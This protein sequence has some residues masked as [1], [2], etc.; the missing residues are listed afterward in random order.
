MR[1]V[2]RVLVG[3]FMF[4]LLLL[5]PT[6]AQAATTPP[7]KIPLTL[8]L[9]QE[10][11]NSPIQSEGFSTIDLRQLIIDLTNEN[12]EFRDQFYQRLQTQINRSKTPLGLDLSESLIQGE[13]IASKLGLQTPLSQAAL[14]SLLSPIEQE[15]LQTDDRFFTKPGEQIPLVTVFRGPL[16]FP[17]ARFTGI[18]SFADTLFLQRLEASQTTFIQEV[19]CSNTRFDRLAD[20]S[21]AT[22]GRGI[23]FSSSAFFDNANFNQVQFLGVANFTGSTFDSTANFLQTEFAQLANFSRTRWLQTADFREVNWHD[24]ALLNKSHFAK[25]LL[26][27]N[28]TLEK[29]TTFRESHFQEPVVLQ[30]VSL[31]DQVDFSSARFTQGAYLNVA[32]MTFD[33]NLAKILGDTGRIGRVFSVSRLQDNEDVLR[34]LVRNFRNQQQIPDANQLEYTTQQLRRQQLQRYLLGKSRINPFSPSWLLDALHWLGLSLLLLLSEDGTSFGLVFGVG[35]VAIAFFSLLFWLIDRWRRRYPQPILPTYGETAYMLGTFTVV[36]VTGIV[37]IFRTGE[38]PWL[39]LLC[40]GNILLPV[41]LMLVWRLYQKGRYHNL[42][43]VSY[44]VEDGSLRQLH[45]LVGRL[46]IMPRFSIFR[47]RYLP[48]LWE[49]RWSWLNYYDFSLNNLLKFGFN[50]IRLRDEHLP[51]II[52]TLAWYQWSLGILYIALLL[53]T[54]SRTIPGL[55]LF[56]YL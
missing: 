23:S 51:G 53:W 19:D 40:L 47:D 35:M 49:R 26:L 28:A 36:T 55:N 44:F 4:L 27:T 20:F 38:Q 24:R 25:S 50:D 21:H 1:N 39:T 6:T 22:F 31:L 12:G 45:L 52:T 34:N 7:E 43:D 32:G 17:Q 9:L 56:I 11:L 41:P 18:V 16:K 29:S 48:I 30:D 8:E 33:S 10:R 2:L 5:L 3:L 15:Q 46:P 13:F 37:T 42:L 54:L 14:S